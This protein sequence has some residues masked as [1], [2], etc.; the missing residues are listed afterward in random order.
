MAISI[1]KVISRD[2]DGKYRLSIKTSDGQ[3]ISVP[4]YGSEEEAKAGFEA[5]MK[6]L[7]DSPWLS[8][9]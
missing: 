7:L 9:P 1:D 5:A 2:A 6:G 8:A 4:G 3:I